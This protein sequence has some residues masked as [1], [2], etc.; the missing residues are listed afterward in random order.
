MGSEPE[1]GVEE[2]HEA[3]RTTD[4]LAGAA[5]P[6]RSMS[7][8]PEDGLHQPSLHLAKQASLRPGSSKGCFTG[9]VICC[10]IKADR[11]MSETPKK[12]ARTEGRSIWL[13]PEI[14]PAAFFA[15]NAFF[16]RD[17]FA[18]AH[19]GSDSA[20]RSALAYYVRTGVLLNIRRGVYMVWGAAFDPW[21]LPSKV[22]PKAVLAYDGAATFHGLAA[23]RHS[24]TYLAPRLVPR[25][26]LGEV[27]FTAVV[28][29]SVDELT[30]NLSTIRSYPHQGHTIAV[31]TAERT[32]ADCL[33]NLTL[34]PDVEHLFERFL[35]QPDR[36]LSLDDLVDYATQHT[37]P[38]AAARLGLLLSSHPKH[39]YART[40]LAALHRR[41]PNRTS[42]ATRNREPGGMYFR[43]WRLVVPMPFAHRLTD[44]E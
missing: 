13:Q 25:F 43:R 6:L 28:D 26:D 36:P 35:S 27:I 8:P 2:L 29:P 39:R 11:H 10:R 34:G 40:H 17:E 12:R 23:L 38:V 21:L 18:A 9:V 16:R 32:L 37:G 30:A 41:V 22:H 19:G 7:L 20:V 14:K 33:D 15:A 3:D 1:L 24:L 42:F 5:Q 44:E 4:S 31:T